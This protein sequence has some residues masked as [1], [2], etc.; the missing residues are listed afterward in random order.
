MSTNQ[1]YNMFALVAG[2]EVGSSISGAGEGSS[3]A[4]PDPSFPVTSA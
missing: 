4:S 2:D 3:F 1:L